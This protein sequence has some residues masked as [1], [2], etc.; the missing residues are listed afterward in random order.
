MFAV[1]AG[2]FLVSASL[3]AQDASDVASPPSRG[4]GT[5]HGMT[6]HPIASAVRFLR[7]PEAPG[8]PRP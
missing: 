4:E 5:G 8:K 3:S 1:M 7:G 6:D 2:S